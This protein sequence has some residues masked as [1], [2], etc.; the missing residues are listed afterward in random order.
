MLREIV[1]KIKNELTCKQVGGD[2]RQNGILVYIICN[3]FLYAV[4]RL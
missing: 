4:Q 1:L 3:D 2:N